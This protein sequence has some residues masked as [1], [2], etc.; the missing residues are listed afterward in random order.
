M[1]VKITKTR[2]IVAGDFDW[3]PY[4]DGWNGKSLKINKTVKTNDKHTK[5]YCHEAYAQELLGS[6]MHQP[7][8]ISK[9]LKKNTLV[10]IDA[11]EKLMIILFLQQLMVVQ[12]I[13]VLI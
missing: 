6:Y 12:T 11:Y 5:V 3:A 9:E 7:A 2:E 13:L 4:N 10:K 1:A 8:P